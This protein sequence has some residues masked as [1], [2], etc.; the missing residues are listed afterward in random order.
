MDQDTETDLNLNFC[1]PLQLLI[2]K[3]QIPGILCPS[4]EF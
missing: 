1:V 4:V 2:I 3:F